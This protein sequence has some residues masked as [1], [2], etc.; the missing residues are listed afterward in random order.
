MMRDGA[1]QRQS[2]VR[3]QRAK[4]GG[5]ELHEVASSETGPM[6]LRIRHQ[7]QQTAIQQCLSPPRNPAGITSEDIAEY[8]SRQERMT[9]DQVQ[10]CPLRDIERRLGQRRWYKPDTDSRGA[11]IARVGCGPPVV[12]AVNREP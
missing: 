8:S 1:G 3:R 12:C 9:T 7:A 10:H 6:N 4:T 2:Q 5:R 11:A